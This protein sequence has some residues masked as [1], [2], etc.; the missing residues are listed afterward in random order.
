MTLFR[1]EVTG[2]PVPQGRARVTRWGTFYPKTSKAHRAALLARFLEADCAGPL[3]GPL[4]LVIEVAGARKNSDLDNHA[5]M[6]LD[7]LQDAQIIPA[8][9]VRVVQQLTVRAI[10]G[11]PRTIVE[12]RQMQ[13]GA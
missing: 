4:A 13:E 8:D 5:K 7:A 6:V 10:G 2:K 11:E 1:C 9:D 12:I 3:P